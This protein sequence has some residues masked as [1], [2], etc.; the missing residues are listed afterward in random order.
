[1][2]GAGSGA[3]EGAPPETKT[4]ADAKTDAETDAE[5]DA[6]AEADASGADGAPAIPDDRRGDWLVLASWV[7]TA[8]FVLMAGVTLVAVDAVQVPFIVLCGLLFVAGL[9]AFFA[10]YAVA[11]GRSRSD[12]IG[13]GGLY[14]LLGS[15]P[16]RVRRHLLVSFT[17]QIVA[18]TV[19]ASVGFAV[20]PADANNPLA[21]GFLVPMF[22]LGVTGLWGARFGTFPA[23]VVRGAGGNRGRPAG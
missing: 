10:A 1:M 13:M 15:A 14:F 22:G 20:V 19:A 5:A 2:S 7:G 6:G 9:L 16:P 3:T 17:V 21:F 23:R 8:V 4:K 18:A 11:V 12:A